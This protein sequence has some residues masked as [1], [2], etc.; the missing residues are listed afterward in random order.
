METAFFVSVE[1]LRSEFKASK[2]S[3]FLVSN[4]HKVECL[5][6]DVIH[7]ARVRVGDSGVNEI[8]KVFS[9]LVIS[10]VDKLHL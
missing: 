7:Q 10:I 1:H 2:L 3:N 5:S 9:V 4:S 6:E 8:T